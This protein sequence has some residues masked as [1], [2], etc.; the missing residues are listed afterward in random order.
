MKQKE[1][2]LEKDRIAGLVELLEKANP[3]FVKLAKDSI[4]NKKTVIPTNGIQ[5]PVTNLV[6]VIESLQFGKEYIQGQHKLHIDPGKNELTVLNMHKE[7]CPTDII[8]FEKVNGGYVQINV[9]YGGKE[10]GDY[11]KD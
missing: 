2:H 9:C 6:T 5:N 3:I 11:K 1:L 4:R 10:V 8:Y 7:E